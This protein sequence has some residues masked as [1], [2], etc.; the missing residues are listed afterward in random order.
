[1]ITS[2]AST[3]IFDTDETDAVADMA[4]IRVVGDILP[5]T[6]TASVDTGPTS[7]EIVLNAAD[8]AS[9]SGV[10]RILYSINDGPLVAVLGAS[11][12]IHIAEAGDHTIRFQA[13]DRAGNVEQL[14]RL[15]A[16]VLPPGAE[17]L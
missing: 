8:N 16:S 14:R 12:T 11:A 1:G 6:T 9:G 5:P 3:A 15:E 7:V 17:I 4:L 13:I 10:D 2:V